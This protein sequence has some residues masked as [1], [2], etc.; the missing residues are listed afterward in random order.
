M[1]LKDAKTLR[2]EIKATGLHCI[3]PLGYKPRNY[4]AR[5][6]LTAGG[7]V[8]FYDREQWTAYRDWQE[9]QRNKRQMPRPRSVIDALVDE[10]C[11]VRDG[12]YE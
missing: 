3:V 12:D 5:I 4:F 8:D 7:T 10:A 9:R 1:T 6:F 11:G 2:D